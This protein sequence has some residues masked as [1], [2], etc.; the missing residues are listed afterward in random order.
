MQNHIYPMKNTIQL[1]SQLW[2]KMIDKN[3]TYWYL[4]FLSSFFP[5]FQLNGSQYIAEASQ[6]P[7]KWYKKLLSKGWNYRRN[8]RA[9]ICVHLASSSKVYGFLFTFSWHT[10]ISQAERSELSPLVNCEDQDV[11]NFYQIYDLEKQ[12]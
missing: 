6:N 3:D 5:M 8:K 1:R 12:K 7:W 9:F 2:I 4:H 11:W 10:T